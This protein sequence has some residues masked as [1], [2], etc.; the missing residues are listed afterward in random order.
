MKNL[1][2]YL[3]KKVAIACRTDEE[4]KF[5]ND[6]LAKNGGRNLYY[7][8]ESRKD[9]PKQYHNYIEFSLNKLPLNCYCHENYHKTIGYTVYEASEFLKFNF[10]VGKWYK[11]ISYGNINNINYA[12]IKCFAQDTLSAS[13]WILNGSFK[14]SGAW[15]INHMS[16]IELLTDLSEIQPYLPETH[17]DKQTSMEHSEFKVGDWVKIIQDGDGISS[18]SQV[19]LNKIGKFVRKQNGKHPFIV[20]VP[21]F[22]NIHCFKIIPVTLEEIETIAHTLTDEEIL[23]VCKQ[24]YP[25]GTKFQSALNDSNPYIGLTKG[26]PYLG[27]VD[28]TGEKVVWNGGSI[29]FLYYQK[30]G[31]AKIIFSPIQ[32]Q[33]E[34]WKPPKKWVIKITDENKKILDNWRRI[35]SNFKDRNIE[36]RNWLTS[37]NHDNCYNHWCCSIPKGYT[38]ITFDQFKQYILGEKPTLKIGTQFEKVY[39][40]TS[41]EIYNPNEIIIPKITKTKPKID[42]TIEKNTFAEINFTPSVKP[43]KVVKFIKIE[44]FELTF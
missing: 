22:G 34:E 19:Y 26:I 40:L 37:N 36:F 11:F 33:K 23:E 14:E 15:N 10:Q 38:E 31:F 17:P 39:P 44:K 6:F 5:V 27:K 8:W 7:H 9:K 18:I 13:D 43:K 35:Q 1:K 41:E 28:R 21:N 3:G 25:V 12:K 4:A 42:F 2:D 24:F 30:N 16:E 32:K 20:D 29:G